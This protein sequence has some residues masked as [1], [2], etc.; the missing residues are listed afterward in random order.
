MKRPLK[1]GRLR[2]AALLFLWFSAPALGQD[3][4]I[5]GHVLDPGL[6]AVATAVVTVTEVDSGSIRQILSN[7]QGYFHLAALPP[8]TYRI[9]AIK[10]GFRMLS[11]DVELS[12]G[13][14]ATVDLRMESAINSETVSLA[15]RKSGAG[16]LLAFLC[17]FPPDSGCET[18][19]ESVL[20]A[21]LGPGLSAASSGPPLLP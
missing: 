7:A 13:S 1:S 4:R 3:C 8:G 18:M 9:E 11:R 17:A 16:S 20:Q 19:L 2:A 14:L 12:P 10:P 5:A 15:A 6:T 21:T